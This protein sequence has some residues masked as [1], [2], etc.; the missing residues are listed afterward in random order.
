M[1]LFVDIVEQTELI[2]EDGLLSRL[3][4]V[5]RAVVRT[6]IV[7]PLVAK[8]PKDIPL[9]RVQRTVPD[10]PVIHPPIRKILVRFLSKEVSFSYGDCRLI[11][12]RMVVGV[13]ANFRGRDVK[14]PIDLGDHVGVFLL[15]PHTIDHP[16][17]ALSVAC[18]HG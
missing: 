1:R 10:H 7:L 8:P 15:D 3:L 17:S 12:R 9:Q 4:Q 11:R 6:E 5:V 14:D 2:L 13:F 16:E 18:T